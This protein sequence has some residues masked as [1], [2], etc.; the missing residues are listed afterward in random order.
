M[1]RPTRPKPIGEGPSSP[2]MTFV[3]QARLPQSCT[4]TGSGVVCVA[5]EV[6]PASGQV[7]GLGSQGILPCCSLLLQGVLPGHNL[8][9]GLEEAL[10]EM[11]RRFVGP[12]QKAVC[13]AIANAYEA[14]LRSCRQGEAAPSHQGIAFPGTSSHRNGCTRS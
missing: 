12:P 11:Q 5:L 9:R 3:G 2:T 6:D 13:T 14:F 1:E 10:Q 4:C 8:D 7:V